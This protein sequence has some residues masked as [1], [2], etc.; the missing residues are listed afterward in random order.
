MKKTGVKHRIRPSVNENFNHRKKNWAPAEP[1]NIHDYKDRKNMSE[2]LKIY[3]ETDS[4]TRPLEQLHRSRLQCK[5]GCFE[6][7]VD[8]ITVFEVEADNIR[9]HYSE[10]LATARPHAVGQCAFLDDNGAC[11]IY[12][13][14]PYVCRTQGLPLRWI[15]NEMEFRDICPLNDEGPALENLPAEQC[16][17]I[18]P[19]E[20]RLATLQSNK[21]NKQMKRIA[22]RDLFTKQP[23]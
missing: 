13:Q 7:C 5:K 23:D 19:V 17:S 16:W 10:L 6:C 18:G 22:L 2:L 1:A 14:R 4:R 15:E 9:A 8:D 21:A 3:A 12:E 11:R 20:A